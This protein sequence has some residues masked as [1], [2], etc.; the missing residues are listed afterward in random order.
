MTFEE[1]AAEEGSRF[2]VEL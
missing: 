1:F 2:A